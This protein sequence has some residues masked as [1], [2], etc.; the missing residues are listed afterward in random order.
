MRFLASLLLLVL[1][2]TPLR[3][4]AVAGKPAPEFAAVD[5]NGKPVKLSDF[6]GKIVVLEWTNHDCPYV[7]KHYGEGNMQGLQAEAT[8]RGVVW[9]SVVSS[10]PGRQGYV[11]GLEANKLT[12]D[13]KAK[14][15]AVLLDPNGSLGRSYG[16]TATPHMYVVAPDGMLAYAGAI[17]DKPGT[18]PA[19][20]KTARNFVRDALAAVAAG[21]APSPAQTRAYGCSVKYG[22]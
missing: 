12:D 4:Q 17:D 18:N 21:T 16:A 6:K 7:R 10:A 3:A 9:L 8:S 13:R 19:E 2:A 5:S 1:A 22:S 15:T 14:P 11:K 20:I